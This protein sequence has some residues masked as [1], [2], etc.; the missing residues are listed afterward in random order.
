MDEMEAVSETDASSVAALHSISSYILYD[1]S[2]IISPFPSSPAISLAQVLGT[3]HLS[4]IIASQLASLLLESPHLT[5]P[6][7]KNL[8]WL[9]TAYNICAHLRHWE[10]LLDQ[11]N[12]LLLIIRE[13]KSV[14]NLF[15]FCF[16]L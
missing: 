12:L 15:S 16:T 10:T 2:R 5:H 9:P 7:F 4:T 13:Q 14:N 1:T 3:P 8:Q 6:T 11:S